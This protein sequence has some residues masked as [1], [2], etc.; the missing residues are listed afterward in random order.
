MS[1]TS[2]IQDITIEHDKD[3]PEHEIEIEKD[4]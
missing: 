2:S 4:N 1:K 3:T